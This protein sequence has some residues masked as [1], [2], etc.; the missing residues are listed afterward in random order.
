MLGAALAYDPARGQSR[1]RYAAMTT[2][3]GTNAS[4][5]LSDAGVVIKNN[6]LGREK[7]MPWSNVGGATI[8]P[9][10]W[11]TRPKFMVLTKAE[12]VMAG[13]N[14]A[15]LQKVAARE[16]AEWFVVVP[17]G[18]DKKFEEL[19]QEINRRV[20]QGIV[21]AA[22]SA[23]QAVLVRGNDGNKYAATFHAREAD[24]V[25][26]VFPNGEQHWVSPE[27]VELAR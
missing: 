24:R 7:A 13:S 22:F 23:G 26:V 3:K 9:G 14:A 15:L 10:N 8:Q 2:I 1:L 5:T 6:L 27:I 17:M 20:A 19:R 4:I 21:N 12:A 25:L 18:A 16:L 11:L